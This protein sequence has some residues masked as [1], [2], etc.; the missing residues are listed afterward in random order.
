MNFTKY[1][2]RDL[3]QVNPSLVLT[4]AR[5]HVQFGAGN[6]EKVCSTLLK[7]SSVEDNR[8]TIWIRSRIALYLYEFVNYVNKIYVNGITGRQQKDFEVIKKKELETCKALSDTWCL[9]VSRGKSHSTAGCTWEP[10]IGQ[11]FTR[12]QALAIQFSHLNLVK[13]Y[14]LQNHLSRFWILPSKFWNKDEWGREY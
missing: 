6:C 14:A 8:V 12:P 5:L 3:T 1:T 2:H 10:C 7:S 4:C 13:T 11:G 9:N